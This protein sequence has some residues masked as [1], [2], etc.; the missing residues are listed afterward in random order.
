MSKK[1]KSKENYKK[2]LT[3]RQVVAQIFDYNLQHVNCVVNGVRPD[4][5]GVLDE[6]EHYKEH[7]QAYIKKRKII[8]GINLK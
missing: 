6:L 4:K 3:G 1:T 5:K 2:A 8:L 7:Q